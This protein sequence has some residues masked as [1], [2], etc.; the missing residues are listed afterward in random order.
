MYQ[1]NQLEIQLPKIFKPFEC[2]QLVRL[3]KDGDGGYLVNM[4]DVEKSNLLISLGIGNDWSFEKDFSKINDCQIICFD[5]ESC[6]SNDDPFF[7][8]HRKMIYKNI[9]TISSKDTVCFESIFQYDN[10]NI[11]L[12]C[13]IEEKEYDFLDKIIQY[14]YKFSAIVI[15]FHEIFSEK[16]F[17]DLTNFISKVNQKIVHLHANNCTTCK[18]GELYVP[19]AIEITF[20][21]SNNINYNPNL[22][23][24][25]SFDMKNCNWNDFKINF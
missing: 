7:T 17:N 4:H 14:S 23:L 5:K 21:S 19:Y 9:D 11:F 15:E 8:N 20:T 6:V 16:N 3:G 1:T 13:D 22:T 24:P 18:K 2:N 12:K 25:H 10:N